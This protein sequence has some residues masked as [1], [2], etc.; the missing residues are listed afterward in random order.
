MQPEKRLAVDALTA[1]FIVDMAN[2][3]RNRG[4]LGPREADLARFTAL[5]EALA[6]HARDDSVQVYAVCDHAVLVDGRHTAAERAQLRAWHA[7]GRIEVLPK[8][9]DRV[10]ELAD[11]TGRP[12]VSEDNFAEY[13]RTYPWIPGCADR[14][15]RPVAVDAPPGIAV[16]RRVVPVPAEWQVSRKEEEGL[17]L[18]AGLYD[19][20]G[21]GGP[22]RDLLGRRWGCPEPDCP[23]F[24]TRPRATGPLPLRRSGTV[25][26]PTHLKPL[27]DLGPAPHRSQ[28]KVRIDG[29]VRARRLITEGAD[30]VVG[31]APAEGPGGLALAAWLGPRAL[32]WISRSHVTIS[33][34][35]SGGL[36]V[37]DTSANGTVIRRRGGESVRL[38]GQSW[39]LRRDDV[40]L[41][42][43]EV[44]LMPSGREFAFGEEAGEGAD[45]PGGAGAAL[46]G[47][48]YRATWIVPPP[49][50][51]RPSGP[52]GRRRRGGRK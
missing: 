14:F 40:V 39:T 13:H 31:R 36:V 52:A 7:E 18:A 9:D 28:I 11:S 29:T 44:E 10:L 51:P 41:L 43:D 12:V 2:V 30:L 46:T 21:S 3:I 50:P 38:R 8:A 19:R 24:G 17:L 37:R 4:L 16:R 33:H 32:D 45:G 34:T 15:L 25:T 49:R 20:R 26:C 22:R 48:E 27:T 47:E 42:H 5:L 23:A 6:H 1:D 35:G